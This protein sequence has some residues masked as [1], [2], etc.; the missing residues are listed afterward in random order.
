MKKKPRNLIKNKQE[1]SSRSGVKKKPEKKI[2]VKFEFEMPDGKIIR[3]G[4]G[5]IKIMSD[6]GVSCLIQDEE[7]KW[8]AVKAKL[9]T[10]KIY[11]ELLATTK[12][13]S[14]KSSR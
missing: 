8:K 14:R 11:Y 2:K 4:E 1:M 6:G 5:R 3:N 12:R 10:L 9:K 7:G 13:L